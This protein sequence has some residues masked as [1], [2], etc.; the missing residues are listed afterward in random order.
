M[1][2]NIWDNACTV[3]VTD[4]ERQAFSDILNH[5][6][7]LGGDVVMFPLGDKG[8]DIL[9]NAQQAYNRIASLIPA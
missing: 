4:D 6:I 1:K 8:W 7:A 5:L 2:Y 3:T 9:V